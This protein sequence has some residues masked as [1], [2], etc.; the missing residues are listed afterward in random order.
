MKIK[1][2][3]LFLFLFCLLSSCSFHHS[4]NIKICETKENIKTENISLS[5]KEWE[6]QYMFFPIPLIFY[7]DNNNTI[8]FKKTK[9]EEMEIWIKQDIINNF[10]FIKINKLK[11]IIYDKN[12]KKVDELNFPINKEYDKNEK[13]AISYP[14]KYKSSKYNINIILNVT[15]KHNNF[16]KNLNFI[17][18]CKYENYFCIIPYPMSGFGV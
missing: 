13:F 18:F 9:Y 16:L 4:H 14:N 8:A 17:Y 2:K 5:F 6:T 15:F 12:Y 7:N 10:S 11:I 3:I 1:I